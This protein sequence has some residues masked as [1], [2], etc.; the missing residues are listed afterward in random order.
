M[1]HFFN[2][3]VSQ[4]PD[5]SPRR[6]FHVFPVGASPHAH[7]ALDARQNAPSLGVLEQSAP[8]H[9]RRFTS[10]FLHC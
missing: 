8:R 4:H 2:Q 5:D 10:R 7:A 3:A 9:L 6:I 1:E